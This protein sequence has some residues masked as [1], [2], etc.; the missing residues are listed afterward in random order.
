M[1]GWDSDYSY[2][3]RPLFEKTFRCLSFD[4]YK[5][6]HLKIGDKIIMPSS[7]LAEIVSVPI[8]FPLTFQME[9]YNDDVVSHC[10]VLEF[11][12]EEGCIHMPEWMMKNMKIQEGDL[13]ILRNASLPR[14]TYM[15]L[16]PHATVFTKLSD[17]R[18]VL[19]KTL[20]DF[21]CLS[22]GDTIMVQH[23]DRD[24]YLDVLEVLP[25]G[26]VN[27]INTDC[28]VDFAP[29]LD[30]KEPETHLKDIQKVDDRGKEHEE[31]KMFVPFT[32][33]ARRLDGIPAMAET[34][35]E[36]SAVVE[37]MSKLVIDEGKKREKDGGKEKEKEKFKP[38]TGKSR[39]LGGVEF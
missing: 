34:T 36:C 23:N 25:G 14:A 11:D 4:T 8:K 9:G 32:G 19:E 30:Y 38:F 7:S 24:F 22:N 18:A 26:A 1:A 35:G 17:P 6:P 16:Q 15:K 12:A 21:T 28:Q 33:K 5:N 13:V 3:P 27:L 2:Q 10:G 20:R 31:V 29:P 39:V 37:G